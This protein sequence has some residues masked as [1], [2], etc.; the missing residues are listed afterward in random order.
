MVCSNI[1]HLDF[2]DQYDQYVPS[3]TQYFD[4]NLNNYQ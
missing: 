4:Q 1:D 2:F 3:K